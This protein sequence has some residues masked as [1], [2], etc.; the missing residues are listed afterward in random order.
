MKKVESTPVF[1]RDF[2]FLGEP[3]I[4]RRRST[5]DALF[6]DDFQQSPLHDLAPMALPGLANRVPRNFSVATSLDSLNDPFTIGASADTVVTI[7]GGYT[8]A[9]VAA[10]AV[11]VLSAF[12]LGFNQGNMNTASPAMRYDLGIPVGIAEFDNVWG[13][14]VSIYCLGALLGCSAGASFAE[15]IGRKRC[16]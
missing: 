4:M 6:S 16:A 5:T 8:P 10:A 14:C 2:S 13:F 11:A 12:Q 9:M 7:E 3:L 15:S 1:P